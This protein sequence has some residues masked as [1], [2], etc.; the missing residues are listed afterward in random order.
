MANAGNKWGFALHKRRG[1]TDVGEYYAVLPVAVL[2]DILDVALEAKGRR[3]PLRRK[4]VIPRYDP[5]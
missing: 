4:R 2:M 3:L 1:T 5:D